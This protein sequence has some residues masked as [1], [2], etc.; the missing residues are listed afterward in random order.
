MRDAVAHGAAAEH[1]DRRDPI[2]GEAN[3]R[4]GRRIPQAFYMMRA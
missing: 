2:G 4:H 1:G 3:I